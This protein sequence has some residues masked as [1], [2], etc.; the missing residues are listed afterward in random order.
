MVT[1]AAMIQM[2][3]AKALIAQSSGSGPGSSSNIPAQARPEIPAN[4][5]SQPIQRGDVRVRNHAIE[6]NPGS[7]DSADRLVAFALAG[8]ARMAYQLGDID[9]AM[10]EVLASFARQTDAAGA[11]DGAGVTPVETAQIVLSKLRVDERLDEA[12]RLENALGELPPE[13]LLPDRP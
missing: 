5:P 9:T 13:Y 2:M 3:L 6:S 12:A 10:S 1:P 7:R 8:R 4:T 11:R